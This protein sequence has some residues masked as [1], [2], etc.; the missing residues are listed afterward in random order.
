[1]ATRTSDTRKRK[2]S[3]QRCA[4]PAIAASVSTI[5]R[6]L[7]IPCRSLPIGRRCIATFKV[8]TTDNASTLIGLGS[9]AIGRVA[10]GYAQNDVAIGRYASLIAS[11]ELATSKGYRLTKEDR[12][13]AWIIERLMCDFQV[14]FGAMPNGFDLPDESIGKANLQ[15]Q[16]LLAEGI[17]SWRGDM[18]RVDTQLR[19]LVRTV[20]SCFDAYFGD[21][22]RTHA[23]AA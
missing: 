23:T 17:V 15:L 8:Y 13:R 4:T 20:A 11:G 9:S 1:M 3:Q 12:V 18:L 6:F 16:A 2:R 21:V 14:D 7:R 5:S 10:E 22:G 19:F